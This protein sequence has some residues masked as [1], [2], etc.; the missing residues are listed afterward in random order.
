MIDDRCD[1]DDLR[2]SPLLRHS[3]QQGTRTPHPAGRPTVAY[4]VTF[5][6][7]LHR[8]HLY[9]S[10]TWQNQVLTKSISSTNAGL[11]PFLYVGWGEGSASTCQRAFSP[12][13]L[14]ASGISNFELLLSVLLSGHNGNVAVQYS[15][16]TT[17]ITEGYLYLF[18]IGQVLFTLHTI[19]QR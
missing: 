2:Y 6:F 7:W 15:I 4:I 18:R 8:L 5:Q 9:I 19:L 1:D 16:R 10:C 11:T 14:R 12:Q 3:R 17:S 13:S